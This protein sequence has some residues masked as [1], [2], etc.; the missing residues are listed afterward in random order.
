MENGEKSF[1]KLF[2]IIELIASRREARPVRDIAAALKMPESTVYRM[3]RFLT[4]RG[5]VERTPAGFI[6][7]KECL[8]LGETAQEQNILPRLARPVLARLAD[9]T[10]ET[11]HLAR[12]QGNHIVYI[13][14]IDGGRSIRMG[15]V[16][17]SASPLH[18]TGVGKAMLAALPDDELAERL[19]TL[20]LERF[21]ATTI[22][23]LP[24]LKRELE[25]IRRRGCS[26]DDNEHEL[27]I[28]CIGAAVLD[29]SGR[30]V[31]GISVAGSS[32]RL[33][34][35]AAAV[36]KLVRAAAREISEKL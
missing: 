15:S 26:F 21:T 33:K 29:R 2:D 14:K 1:R 36:A 16:I 13:D 4:R 6:L 3:L 25:A 34:P 20:D 30:C 11:V 5:Y 9:A 35:E 24:T 8:F 12:M 28:F 19:P 10:S 23:S 22:C 7:G 27:G 31:A 18:C 32:I 17:G